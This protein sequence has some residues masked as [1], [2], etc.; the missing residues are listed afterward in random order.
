[1]SENGKLVT[2]DIYLAAALMSLGAK[3]D[4]VDRDDP[5]HMNFKMEMIVPSNVTTT[6]IPQF[7]SPTLSS[8][9][10]TVTSEPI[11]QL[12]DYEKKWMNGELLVNAVKFAEAIKR[13][14]SVVHSRP[15]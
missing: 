3:L 9:S 12:S 2:S 5:R 15:D 6:P 11:N 1:M 7:S 13:M 8:A 10:V 14:K 4:N